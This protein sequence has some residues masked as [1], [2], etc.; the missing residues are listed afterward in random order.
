LSA[1]DE[2]IKYGGRDGVLDFDLIDSAI[3]R[4]YCGYYRTISQKAAAL[5][6]SMATNHGFLDG[7][8]RST[9]L[10]VNLLI[11]KSGYRLS[12]GAQRANEEVGDVILAVVKRQITFDEL[13]QWFEQR[14]TRAQI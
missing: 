14:L 4:P 5:V 2:A 3:A 6:E 11:T 13:V 7:N 8:K 1:H 12:G 10:L 9:L